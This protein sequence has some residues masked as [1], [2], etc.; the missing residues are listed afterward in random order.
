MV[1][2][3][4]TKEVHDL[5]IKE[6]GIEE[7]FVAKI[8]SERAERP[9]FAVLWGKEKQHFQ[10]IDG[11]HRAVWRYRH[12]LPTFSAYAIPLELA[13]ERCLLQLP[14]GYD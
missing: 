9:G 1:Q 5:L 7:S 11:N 3:A 12:G 2:T 13:K 4:L 8:T 10:I 14:A 6:C